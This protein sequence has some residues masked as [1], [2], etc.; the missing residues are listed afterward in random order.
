MAA[1]LYDELMAAGSGTGLVNAG[2]HALT[3]LRI[4]KGYRAWGHEVT[5]DDSP[6]EA[7][8][9]FATKMR[10]DIPFV[11]RQALLEQRKTGLVRRLVHLKLD[12]P[13]IFLLGDEPIRRDGDM[14]GQ[15]TS[16]AYGHSLGASVAMGYVDLDDRP[17]AAMIDDGVFEVECATERFPV[18]V[19]LSPFFDPSGKR[20]KANT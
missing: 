11:G 8:L 10:S 4:E 15:I 20:M 16:A 17:L 5:P 3:S 19:S 9:G 12:D 2:T 14:V 18:T 7:G 6:L 1:A 13:K